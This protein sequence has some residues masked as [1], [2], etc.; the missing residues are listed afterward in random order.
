MTIDRGFVEEHFEYPCRRSNRT[1]DTERRIG[2]EM[3]TVTATTVE[4][5]G[6]ESVS[7]RWLAESL[8]RGRGAILHHGKPEDPGYELDFGS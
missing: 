2:C 8:D 1:K 4:L 7:A 5:L 3:E 6:L